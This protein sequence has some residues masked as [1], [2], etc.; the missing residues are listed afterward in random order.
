MMHL[1]WK[2]VRSVATLSAALTVALTLIASTKLAIAQLEDSPTKTSDS[3]PYAV[4][5]GEGR[6]VKYQIGVKIRTAKAPFG[7]VKIRLPVP[8]DWPEQSV[9]V[10]EEEIYERAGDIDYRI[11]DGG[12]RQMM[13][14][15]SAI[16]PST[17]ADILITYEV[18]IRSIIA[19]GATDE[20]I[21]PKRI[22]K[23]IK[24]YIGDAP[25]IFPRDKDL[26]KLVESLLEDQTEQTAWES[27]KILH[28]WVI[29]NIAETVSKQ[30]STVDT[31]TKMQGCN[32][33]RA[34]LFVAM[35]RS[36]KIPARLVMDEGSQYAEVCLQDPEG[37]DR[38]YP[39]TFLGQGDF[40]ST[41]RP[42]VVFQK[43][44][45]LRV[46]EL[47]KRVRLVAEYVNGKS[48]AKPE[49]RIIR[50]IVQ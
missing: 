47:G 13:L 34:A 46:P 17:A 45:N 6:T 32:E 36:A 29:E 50:Q 43:G 4:T 33:D 22:T 25:M 19:P 42:A 1:I 26:R 7:G 10:S 35:A 23:E 30:Q 20:L 11:L 16:P 37:V 27:T 2:T 18:T 49:V 3:S 14:A 39:C 28:A 44:D 12:V 8:S 31:L 38:W 9:A 41:S 21:I 15:I 40:G 24:W 48:A 5:F